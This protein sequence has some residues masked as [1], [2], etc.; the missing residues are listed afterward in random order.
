[1]DKI[2]VEQTMDVRT[3][4][5]HQGQHTILRLGCRDIRQHRSP[6]LA[7]GQVQHHQGLQQ[8]QGQGLETVKLQLYALGGGHNA[9]PVERI[10]GQISTDNATESRRPRLDNQEG[11]G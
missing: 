5:A 2:L 9:I 10:Q 3:R 11:Q 4:D 6:V 1:M 7:S 8:V